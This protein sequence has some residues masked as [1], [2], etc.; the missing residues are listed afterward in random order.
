[1][2]RTKVAV[3][4]LRGWARSAEV[5]GGPVSNEETYPSVGRL[6]RSYFARDLDGCST[7]ELLARTGCGVGVIHFNCG[8]ELV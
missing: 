6:S 4:I 3:A 5:G 2:L 8:Y 7:E 1:M